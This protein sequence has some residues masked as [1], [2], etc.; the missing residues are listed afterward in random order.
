MLAVVK[1]NRFK[2]RSAKGKSWHYKVFMIPGGLSLLNKFTCEL[3][4]ICE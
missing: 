1:N 3:H 2:I 4:V